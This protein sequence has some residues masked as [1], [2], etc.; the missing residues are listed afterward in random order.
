MNP[1]YSRTRGG[2]SAFDIAG[3]TK[4]ERK[5][6]QK[7]WGRLVKNEPVNNKAGMAASFLALARRKIKRNGRI[8]FVLPLTAAF[9]DSW[10]VTRQMIEQEFTDITAIAVAGGQ[11]LGREA[12]S[13]DTDMEEMLLVATRRPIKDEGKAAPIHCA[14]L[15]SPPS[16]IGEASEI[17]RAIEVALDGMGGVGTSRPIMAGEDELGQVAVFDAGGEGAPWGP[18]GVTHVSLALA[19]GALTKTE[20]KLAHFG[21]TDIPLGVDMSTIDDVFEVGPT[22]HR[23]GHLH[24][25][26]PTGAFEFH[27]VTGPTDSLGKDRALW[28]ANSTEQRKLVVLPTHKR[29]APVNV[30]SDSDRQAMRACQSTLFYARNMRWTRKHSLRRRPRDRHWVV[31]LGQRSAM[32]MHECSRRLRYGRTRHLAW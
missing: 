24:G 2:Q 11:A 15:H 5:A 27:P 17:A 9:A 16:R 25:N 29:S 4:E 10:A 7:R 30:G 12:L 13:A 19:A 18:L 31:A 22:H 23:I 28:E 14:T 26:D 8:G 20:G 1:P 3:L 32:K 21:D 6:C